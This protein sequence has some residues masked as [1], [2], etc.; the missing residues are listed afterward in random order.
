MTRPQF[1]VLVV[2]ASLAVGLKLFTYEF[3]FSDDP[4]WGVALRATPGLDSARQVGE[5]D[6]VPDHILIADENGFV[7]QG[8]YRL[9][10]RGGWVVLSAAVVAVLLMRRSGLL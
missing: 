3:F 10:V 2:I 1:I 9:V 4:M 8:V 7:G 5:H 6:P